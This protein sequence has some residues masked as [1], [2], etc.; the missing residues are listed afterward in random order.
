MMEY[1]NGSQRLSRYQSYIEA[2]H[3][4]RSQELRRIAGTVWRG[5][6]WLVRAAFGGPAR[7]VRHVAKARRLRAAE[8]KLHDLDDRLLDD[9]GIA[10]AE[11]E[12]VVRNGR[13]TPEATEPSTSRHPHEAK[14]AAKLVPLRRASDVMGAI[15]VH[16]PWARYGGDGR[17]RDDAA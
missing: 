6:T 5:V 4:L 13:K 12:T 8:R 16:G 7:L 15:I 2:A 9:I 1:P 10:R 11:I 17:E 3:R 14:R